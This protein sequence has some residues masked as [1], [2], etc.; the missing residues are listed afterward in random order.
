MK[1]FAK[2][3]FSLIILMIFGMIVFTLGADPV[4]GF[5]LAMVPPISFGDLDF[6]DG[7]DNMAGTQL[8]AYYIPIDDIETLPGYMANPAALG[9]YATIDQPIVCK[10]GKNFL[11]L[12]VSPDSGKVEDNKIEGKDS[13]SFKSVYEFFF[14]KN[15]SASLGFQRL[16]GTTKFLVIVLEADG[17]QRILGIKPGVPATLSNVAGTTSTTSTG[18]KGATMQFESIQ[19]GPAPIYTGEIPLVPAV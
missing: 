6:E 8:L 4:T 5:A 12:Y 10:T 14:P 17:N 3:S 9:D 2:I 16:A 15:D 18:E 19:N 11:K 7:Q 1:N 13:N